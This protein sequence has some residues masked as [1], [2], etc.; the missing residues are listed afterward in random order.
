MDTLNVSWFL[1]L[2]P[3]ID[4]NPNNLFYS[5]EIINHKGKIIL[6]SN[7]FTYVINEKT[8][9]LILKKNFIPHLKP[10]AINDF[11]FLVIKIICLFL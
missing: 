9:A 8:G 3:S 10:I 11:L 2:N 4:P 1:N 6:S 7:E 5:T